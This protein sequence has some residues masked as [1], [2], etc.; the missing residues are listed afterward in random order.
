MKGQEVKAHSKIAAIAVA[1]AV[2]AAGL[3]LAPAAATADS[4]P[5]LARPGAPGKPKIVKI[6]SNDRKVTV[7]DARFRPG[8]TEFRVTK[9]AHRGSS[10]LILETKNLDRA[11]KLL[12]KATSGAPGSADAMKK[13]DRLVTIY[14]GGAEGARWQVKLSQGSYYMLDTKTNKLSTFKVKGERRSAKMQKADSTVTT[15]KDN[16]FKTSGPLAGKWVGFANHSRE[17]HF[18]EANK[19]AKSVTAKDVRDALKSNK[20]PNWFR[21][22]G[23]FFEVQSPGIET[24]HFQ[25]VASGRYLLMCWMPSEEQDGVPHAMM[26]MWHLVNAV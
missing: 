18:M 9:T 8:V 12:G 13:F 6:R 1:S 22:G 20:Q 2:T 14:G 16:Q 24:V 23:F 11:F 7:S 21:P 15:T 10:L 5:T 3:A 25:D 4:G 17:I 26:G 19:V